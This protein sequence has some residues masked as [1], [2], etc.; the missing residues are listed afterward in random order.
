MSLLEAMAAGKPIVA[1]SI[2]SQKEV[3]S[4]GDLIWLVRPADAHSL[5][6]GILR[7]VEDP[8]FMA[9]LAANARAVY[10]RCYTEERMLQSYR[11]LYCDLLGVNCGLQSAPG[12]QS[13]MC[14]RRETQSN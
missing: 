9:R 12:G 11:R 7:L 8:P 6:E 5:T 3:A 2:G 4:H 1:T 13:P 10:E 14:Y